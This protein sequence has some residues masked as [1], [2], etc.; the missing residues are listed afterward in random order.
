MGNILR[1]GIEA[2]KQTMSQPKP[3]GLVKTTKPDKYTS[4]VSDKIK[5]K[6]PDSKYRRVAKFLI[7]IGSD[8]AAEILSDLEPEQIQ[9]ISKE[10]ALI[11]TIKPEEAAEILAE[12]QALFSG[13]YNFS[14]VSHGGVEIA[15]RILYAAKGP[16]KGEALLNKAVPSSKENI[17]GF[18]EEFSPEQLVMLLK[19]ESAQTT[20]LIISRLAPKV[21]AGVI[22]KLPAGL[23]PEI[24][25]RAAYQ[26]KISPEIL[27][28]IAAAL[29]EKVRNISGGA[30]DF[31]IDG[32]KALAAIL[33]HG[34][35]SFGDRIVN[36]LEENNP[37][38][39]KDLKEKLYTLEDVIDTI[40]RPLQEK[41]ITMSEKD[42]AVLLKGRGQGFSEKI[43]SCVS[44]G[45]RQII[46]EESE[47]LGA[48]PKRECDDA[49]KE[50]LAWFRA[51]RENGDI[52]LYSDKDVFL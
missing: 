22:N 45:R 42:I 15:R 46:R 49:A 14:G 30:K 17:F 7:L 13:T 4:G 26:E 1:H 44:A 24:L 35:Y 18:L 21:S 3:T 38:I 36:E 10:I 48:V 40:D 20:A 8:Q 39:G 43:L 27:E 50:F 33:K 12:F 31:E 9:E 41:L 37:E 19:T 16:E 28:Q 47:F 23:K 11:K 29:K 6:L 5:E 32:M 52:I 25:R 34:D 2:Y 51:A